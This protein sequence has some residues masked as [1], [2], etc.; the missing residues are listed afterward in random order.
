MRLFDSFI[1]V[2]YWLQI[3]AAP[4]LLSGIAA[5][6]IWSNNRA[7][8]IALLCIGVIVGIILAEF[9]RRKYGLANFFSKLYSNEPEKK[10]AK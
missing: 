5:L 6:F 3:F 7:I 9:I 2:M 10:S 1:N 8:A 4:T